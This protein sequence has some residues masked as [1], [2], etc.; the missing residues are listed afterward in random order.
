MLI[1][2]EPVRF[3]SELEDTA[4]RVGEPMSLM[5]SYTSSQ[6]MHVSWIKNGKP[7]WASYKYNV[8]KTESASTVTERKQLGYILAKFLIP[9]VLPSVTLM[10]FNLWE[11]YSLPG[12]VSSHSLQFST[13]SGS[14]DSPTSRRWTCFLS[15]KRS[16]PP[17]RLKQAVKFVVVSKKRIHTLGASNVEKGQE[18]DLGF[19]PIQHEN[20]RLLVCS[21]APP[22]QWQSY[23]GWKIH[24]KFLMLKFL[25]WLK[26]LC[27]CQVCWRLV[28]LVLVVFVDKRRPDV[29]GVLESSW[30]E[31]S[32]SLT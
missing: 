18:A 16:L 25:S 17:Y 14:T 23:S 27:S 6:Q 13:D 20:N 22:Q 7:V 24:I 30:L 5:C 26:C 29:L 2:S 10:S 21:G 11:R 12:T 32:H 31:V 28:V 8:K 1:L 9:K 3:T 19:V 4:Q 15:T